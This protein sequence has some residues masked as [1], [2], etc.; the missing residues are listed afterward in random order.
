MKI[1]T[2]SPIP[3][4]IMSTINTY[5]L[6]FTMHKLDLLHGLNSNYRYLTTL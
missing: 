2:L 5:F 3:F 4:A 1:G 6:G